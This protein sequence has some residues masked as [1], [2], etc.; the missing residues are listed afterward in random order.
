M[1]GGITRLASIKFTI[2]IFICKLLIKIKQGWAHLWSGLSKWGKMQGNKV[3]L[4]F[5]AIGILVGQH[6]IINTWLLGISIYQTHLSISDNLQHIY[7]INMNNHQHKLRSTWTIKDHD[8]FSSSSSIIMWGSRLL[9][10][11]STAHISVLHSV[12]VVQL[13][14]Q[15]VYPL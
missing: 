4:K 1:T 10:T 7:I 5:N 12:E 6:F 13:Y 8:L 15:A 9:I 3:R 11:V 14:P 2:I